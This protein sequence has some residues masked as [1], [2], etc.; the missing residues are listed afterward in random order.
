[1][2]IA[3]NKSDI[4]ISQRKYILDLLEEE[5]MLGCKLAD[6]PINYNLKLGNNLK[7]H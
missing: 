4:S 6:T 1:M 2:E 3:R 7:V 5:G